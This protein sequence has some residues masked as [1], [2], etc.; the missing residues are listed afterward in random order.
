MGRRRTSTLSAK[1]AV[2]CMRVSTDAERQA[3]G[4]EGQRKAIEAWALREGVTIATWHTDEVSGGAP[5]DKRPGLLAA[6][7]DIDVHNAGL[8][9]FQKVDRFTRD[10]TSAALVGIELQRRG[11]RLA[12]ADGTGSGDDPTS[13]LLRSV[14]VAVAEF[15]RAVIAARIKTALAVKQSRGE[16]TGAPRFGF[17]LGPDGRHVEADAGEQRIVRRVGVLRERG[18][19]VRA[20]VDRLAH[21]GVRGRTGAPLTRTAVHNLIQT[22]ERTHEAR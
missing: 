2:A 6:I 17:R 20:I 7:A 15:E 11:A 16:M 3:L 4:I 13:K 10:A 22:K 9:V 18:L 5:M 19:S 1:I 8:I 21:D 12:F 14:L